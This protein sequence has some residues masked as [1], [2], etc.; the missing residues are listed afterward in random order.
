MKGE[1]KMI[2]FCNSFKIV[3]ADQKNVIGSDIPMAIDEMKEQILD[4]VADFDMCG[5]IKIIINYCHEC[6]LQ[7]EYFVSQRKTFHVT[8]T[9][10]CEAIMNK[11]EDVTTLM[12]IGIKPSTVKF[13]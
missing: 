3:E 8:F 5:K 7:S 13:T 4:K 10:M 9:R 11:H 12:R 2:V 1:L 6:L